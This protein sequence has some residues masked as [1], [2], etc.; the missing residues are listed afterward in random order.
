MNNL[1]LCVCCKSVRTVIRNDKGYPIC[2][3]CSNAGYFER[4]ATGEII[5]LKID[6]TKV[7]QSTLLQIRAMI[8]K[9]IEEAKLLTT[10]K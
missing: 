9:D 5:E 6:T 2:S 8:E 1:E 7:K 10:V 3:A 4:V